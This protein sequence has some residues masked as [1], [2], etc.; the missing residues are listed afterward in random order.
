[1][2][3]H[4]GSLCTSWS[5]NCYP[6][7]ESPY[8]YKDDIYKAFKALERASYRDIIDYYEE[9]KYKIQILDIEPYFEILCTYCIALFELSMYRRFLDKSDEILEL[10]ITHNI[11][12]FEDEDIFSSTLFR[13]AAALYHLG[14]R[15]NALKI[16]QQLIR[17]HPDNKEAQSFYFRLQMSNKEN[18][19]ATRGLA[20]LLLLSS[21]FIIV[22]E[23]LLIRPFYPHWTI[24]I[25]WS[26]NILFFAG[27]A[28]YLLGEVANRLWISYKI[29][30]EIQEIIRKKC[31]SNSGS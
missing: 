20:I 18:A 15:P 31:Q 4:P 16:L 23:L 29:K 21:A 11:Y 9:N 27:I 17:I 6:M 1:M 5:E 22:L 30:R 7:S 13:K 3:P 8:T 26:R 25:E 12:N 28:V 14:D 24:K 19:S 10:S 2:F